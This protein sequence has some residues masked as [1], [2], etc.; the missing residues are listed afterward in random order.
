[1]NDTKSN[2]DV[3]DIIQERRIVRVSHHTMKIR[4][5]TTPWKPQILEVIPRGTRNLRR[6]VGDEDL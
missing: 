1:M 6:I 4:K 2:P 3:F 5:C